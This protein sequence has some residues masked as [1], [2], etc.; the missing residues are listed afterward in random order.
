MQREFKL[1]GDVLRGGTLKKW[2]VVEGQEVRENDVV[3]QIDFFMEEDD[4]LYTMDLLSPITG[5]VSY[6]AEMN[7]LGSDTLMRI[8][9]CTHAT[10]FANMCSFCSVLVDKLPARTK[11]LWEIEHNVIK[12]HETYKTSVHRAPTGRETSLVSVKAKDGLEL[13][14]SSE[15]ATDADS[16]ALQSLRARRKLILILDLDHTLLHG[17]MDSRAA[18][19]IQPD[20]PIVSDMMVF[21]SRHRDLVQDYYIKFRPNLRNF[22][23]K[24]SEKFELHIDTAA[25]KPYA[26]AVAEALDPT[27]ELFGDRI[28]SRCDTMRFER[29]NRKSV[30]WAHRTL[31]DTS[32]TLI[33]DDTEEVWQSSPSLI[34]I[35]PYHF[36]Q[37]TPEREANNISGR[38]MIATSASVFSQRNKKVSVQTDT[39]SDESE[40]TSPPVFIEENPSVLDSILSLLERIHDDYFSRYDKRIEFLEKQKSRSR[41][42]DSGSSEDPV[43]N[44]RATPGPDADTTSPIHDLSQ[45]SSQTP[46]LLVP[47]MPTASEC[48][49]RVR[50]RVLEDCC[51]VFSGVFPNNMPQ[52]IIQKQPLWANMIALGAS[53]AEKVSSS[54]GL[55]SLVSPEYFKSFLGDFL[56]KF[57]SKPSESSALPELSITAYSKASTPSIENGDDE[58]TSTPTGTFLM[59]AGTECCDLSGF[60]SSEDLANVMEQCTDR[61]VT[62]VITVSGGTAKV[63]EASLD[64]EIRIV[65]LKWLEQCIIHYRRLPEAPFVEE[66]LSSYVPSANR[67]QKKRMQNLRKMRYL[68]ATYQAFTIAETEYASFFDFVEVYDPLQGHTF[69]KELA[70]GNESN[71]KQSD[72]IHSEDVLRLT[73]GPPGTVIGPSGLSSLLRRV[74]GVKRN[75]SDVEIDN[76]QTD[77]TGYGEWKDMSTF[78]GNIDSKQPAEVSQDMEKQ[79]LEEMLAFFGQT[80]DEDFS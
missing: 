41:E 32:M 7:K 29:G 4:S 71:V 8:S 63:E 17:T 36:W 74:S 16:R 24:A 53:V 9:Y 10:I 1:T 30:T 25:S 56:P 34:R 26:M 33:L 73:H 20:S 15:L 13:K 18:K 23:I 42:K 61:I 43:L 46:L 51:F 31:G 14:M 47:P 2:L 12:D 21:Q 79:I 77:I 22:L 28:V 70:T 49:A 59:G 3:A 45:V 62:H 37:I 52:A 65:P 50:R 60:N 48:L 66:H 39:T 75:R 40:P 67:D 54:K 76:F 80:N 58:C 6:L 57:H 27:K 35:E 5:K 19:F 69:R 78:G 64:N 44:T 11:K 55:S 38:S 68:E 72:I